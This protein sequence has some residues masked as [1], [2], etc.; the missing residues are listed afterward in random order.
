MLTKRQK[1]E[2]YFSKLAKK[3]DIFERMQ[4]HN[5][6]EILR[7]ELFSKTNKERSKR[8]KQ[9]KR[10]MANVKEM[11]SPL[12]ITFTWDTSKYSIKEIY[13]IL[14]KYFKKINVNK[15]VLVSDIGEKEN[16]HFHGFIDLKENNENLCKVP[17]KKFGTCLAFKEMKEKGFYNVIRKL[18]VINKGLEKSIKYCTKYT[19]KTIE[20]F[21]HK[22]FSSRNKSK[23]NKLL[24]L[25][26]D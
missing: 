20:N 22:I 7:Q 5:E 23:K 4:Y 2:L 9:N 26:E 25:L 21:E 12:F 1:Y 3:S 10:I 6:K 14:K 17:V 18:N 16:I 13:E 8:Y 15:Y 11:E 24:E 19:T